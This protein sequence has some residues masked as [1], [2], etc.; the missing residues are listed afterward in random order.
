MLVNT[1]KIEKQNKLKRTIVLVG[2]LAFVAGL[3]SFARYTDQRVS[4]HTYLSE[5]ALQ[6]DSNKV[7]YDR[8]DVQFATTFSK[9]HHQFEK[10]LSADLTPEQW[11]SAVAQWLAN[12]LQELGLETHVQEFSFQHAA[13]LRRGWNVISIVRAPRGDGAESLLLSTRYDR[14]QTA[15]VTDEVNNL[16]LAVSLIRLFQKQNWLSKDYIF[17]T[18]PARQ[19]YNDTGIKAFMM[20]YYGFESD[21]K[22]SDSSDEHITYTRQYYPRGAII[23]ALNLAID[24]FKTFTEL[25]ILP[26]GT[27]GHLPNL[28]LINTIT[29]V[30]SQSGVN[31]VSLSKTDT[32]PSRLD[33]YVPRELRNLFVFMRNLAQGVP[34]EDQAVLGQYN[35]DAVTIH[36][37]NA[38]K[39]NKGRL[40]PFTLA[41]VIEGTVRSVNNLIERF[42][43]SFYY[44]L[45]INPYQFISIGNY[46]IS[47]GLIIL[48]YWAYSTYSL[49]I[50]PTSEL[51]P[52]FLH[53][54]AAHLVGLLVFAA[55][56]TVR[57]L[58]EIELISSHF[59]QS[60][61]L[62]L[63][64]AITAGLGALVFFIVSAKLL[65]VA[66]QSV[67]R[68]FAM[69]PS[70]L[71][72]ATMALLNF[73]FAT[74]AATFFVPIYGL[75]L[76]TLRP[77]R[78]L[79][80]APL[81]LIY[82]IAIP[83]IGVIAADYVIGSGRAYDQLVDHRRVYDL[84]AA[85]VLSMLKNY[86]ESSSLLFPFITIIVLPFHCLICKLVAYE[87]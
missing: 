27:Q 55:P 70:A 85:P 77:K 54:T 71:F 32:F 48:G 76:L 1:K 81:H 83:F 63:V 3:Y 30:A 51:L 16:G 45:L 66:S 23:A 41:R 5:N 68:S 31:Q 42:H 69:V 19:H 86:L 58:V 35:I 72:L 52:S 80:L 75:I 74:L 10:S 82:I 39:D 67:L 14:P 38:H 8:E 46:M 13:G 56:L 65:P 60:D 64:M 20:D 50:A 47:L 53:V 57:R 62:L 61:Q 33:A 59:L 29:T 36:N 2:I 40:T 4:R 49:Y 7:L 17:V 18:S 21:A 84:F 28:D 44:Y 15:L 9:E 87:L 22:N 24:S 6:P 37:K 34:L 43:Q 26:E 12:K 25:A 73:S 78:N 79:F 11:S